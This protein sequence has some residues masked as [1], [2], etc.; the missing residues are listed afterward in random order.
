[1]ALT[2]MNFSKRVRMSFSV[3][4][5]VRPDICSRFRTVV[6]VEKEIG[7]AVLLARCD[8]IIQNKIYIQT[9]AWT[10]IRNMHSPIANANEI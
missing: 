1:M 3:S 9:R 4:A 7:L 5:G 8:C 6:M 10:V 2:S